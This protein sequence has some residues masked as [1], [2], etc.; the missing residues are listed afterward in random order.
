MIKAILN[1]ISNKL[2]DGHQRSQKTTKNIIAAIAIKGGSVIIN[3]AIVPVT[4]NYINP[5]EYGIWLT[6]SSLI[7]W[8]SFFDIGFGHG[9]RNKFTEAVANGNHN[10]ARS[11]VSTTYA[12]LSVIVLFI[13]LAF[14][15]ANQFIDWTKVLNTNTVA[16]S[17]LSKVA[18]IV[19]SFFCLQFILKLLGTILTANQESAKSS[20]FDFLANFFSLIAI[21]IISKI[22]QHGSLVNLALITG[23]F[24]ALIFMTATLWY[25]NRDLKMYA[26]KLSL[27]NMKDAKQLLGLGINFFFI[28]LAAIFIFETTNIVTTQILGPSEVTVYNIAFKY[29]S[30]ITMM[31]GIVAAPL[32]SATAE[33]YVKKDFIWLK[34]TYKKLSKFWLSIA[35]FTV[36]VLGLSQMAYNLWVGN[37]VAIPWTISALM[38][39]NVVLV[40]RQNLFI[41]FINGTGKIRLQLIINVMLSFVFIPLAI[42]LGKKF[43]LE[44]I[45]FA[46]ILINLVYAIVVP[47][48][49]NLIVNQE[50]KGIWQR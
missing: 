3:L 23:S 39:I 48:Q 43:A 15:F 2:N 35:I 42:I 7:L 29:F 9:L 19:F 50:A 22:S 12:I 37:K 16:S 47:I 30:V 11:Y 28:Q 4:I 44:G 32:W 20:F 31:C 8:F 36:L 1:K 25:F 38:A 6:L 14:L 45:V 26:P 27:V 24:Q 17:N 46:N 41:T 13:W 21:F 49:A 5:T 34:S 33:A 18:L 10:L 40:T